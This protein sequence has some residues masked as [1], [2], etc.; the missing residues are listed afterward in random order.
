MRVKKTHSRSD[1]E[2]ERMKSKMNREK[3]ILRESEFF[4]ESD[5]IFINFFKIA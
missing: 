1:K 4:H 3:K 5:K 2:R